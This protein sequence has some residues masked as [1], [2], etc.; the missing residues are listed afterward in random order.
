MGHRHSFIGQLRSRIRLSDLIGRRVRL[1][2]RGREYVGLCPFHSE[3]T[4]SFYVVDDKGFFHCFGCGAHGDA[5]GFVTR[6]DNLSYT[7]AVEKLAGEAEPAGAK[8]LA[9]SRTCHDPCA[10]A[11]ERAGPIW[12]P[13]LPVPDDAPALLRPDGRTVELINPKRAGECK[14][15]TILRPAAWWLYRDAEGRLLGY[16][17]RMEFER[18]GCRK[19][20]TPQITFC[21]SPGGT[22]RWCIVPFP[23]P[24]PLYGL[25]ELTARP[26]APVVVVE[27]EKTCDAGRSLL[28]AYVVVTWPGGS[29]GIAHVDWSPLSGR[30]VFLLPDAD[31]PGRDAMDGW[32]RGGERV[33]G[34]A[35]LLTAIAERVRVVDPPRYLPDG[36]DLAD[37]NGWSETDAARWL[38]AYVRPGTV[39]TA[40]AQPISEPAPNSP[41]CTGLLPALNRR[42]LE[43]LV[44]KIIGAGEAQLDGTLRWAARLVGDAA[45]KGEIE[46]DV[47]EAV[48][49]RAATRAG[50]TEIEA[51]RTV[52]H[53]FHILQLLMIGGPNE[54]ERRGSRK[55]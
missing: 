10:S 3:K 27:G 2:R 43:G 28:P 25:D 5:I 44:R 8:A 47:A 48:L 32:F 42:R 51:R 37:A 13:I 30:D 22:R 19:K 33:P 26:Q 29:K 54:G 39:A 23:K 24:R 16:V 52:A 53:S 18:D 12:I 50:L 46:P 55:W 17:L 41:M 40:A 21:A 4:P 34:I 15:R 11:V 31:K 7:E 1:V 9:A 45:R 35:E 49:V 14:E 36:W 20:W 38:A 6:A